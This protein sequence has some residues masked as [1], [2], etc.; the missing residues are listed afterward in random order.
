MFPAIAVGVAAIEENE[1]V[2]LVAAF[3][4]PFQIGNLL[5]DEGARAEEA[6]DVSSS[7][8]LR[9]GVARSSKLQL[10]A[11]AARMDAGLS[12]TSVLKHRA[13]PFG[14]RRPL[15]GPAFTVGYSESESDSGSVVSWR[16]IT[17]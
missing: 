12:C 5:H 8:V 3:E 14:K 9:H 4:E 2:L 10:K 7:V 13:F 16:A 6:V 15:E 17:S 1:L 11:L